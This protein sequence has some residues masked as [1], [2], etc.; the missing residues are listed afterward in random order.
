MSNS[1]RSPEE[2]STFGLIQQ[3]AFLNWLKTDSTGSKEIL[4]AV[5]GVQIAK[6][7]LQWLTDQDRVDR[8]KEECI[9]AIA[10]YVKNNPRATQTEINKFVESQVLLFAARVQSLDSASLF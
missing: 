3:M 6:E 8:Y 5:T 4:T 1:N 2:T 7:V 10:D 9:Q